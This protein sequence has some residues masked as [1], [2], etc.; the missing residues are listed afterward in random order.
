[1]TDRLIILSKGNPGAISVLGKLLD[2]GAYSTID[3]LEDAG[4]TGP[5]IWL[6]YEDI[7]EAD[8]D[9]LIE[10]SGRIRELL[11][12]HPEVKAEWDSAA[13]RGPVTT[14]QRWVLTWPIRLKRLL[15]RRISGAARNTTT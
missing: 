15:S 11:A 2:A 4:A 13:P 9:N 5:R 12:S 6:L 8:L 10:F 7:C 1:M 14:R 3:D